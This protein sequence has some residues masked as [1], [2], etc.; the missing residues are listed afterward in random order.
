MVTDDDE[1]PDLCGV[2]ARRLTTEESE[3]YGFR[4]EQC[5]RDWHDRIQAW[6]GGA[7]DD[8]LDRLYGHLDIPVTKH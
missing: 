8:E 5:E 4:C 6:R 1:L 7:P 2:C 3:Y